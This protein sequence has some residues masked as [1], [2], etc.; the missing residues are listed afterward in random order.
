MKNILD[1]LKK[2]KQQEL[3]NIFMKIWMFIKVASLIKLKKEKEHIFHRLMDPLMKAFGTTIKRMAKVNICLKLVS[4]MMENGSIQKEKA[5]ENNILMIK[6]G[7][8]DF[9]KMI[10]N[11]EKEFRLKLVID[12]KESSKMVLSIVN[13]VV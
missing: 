9:G 3:D 11:K 8:K 6:I 1:S 4:I 2:E 13:L 7:M 5:L 10:R 12:S